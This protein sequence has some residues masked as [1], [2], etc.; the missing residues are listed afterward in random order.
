MLESNKLSNDL[1]VA[2][3]IIILKIDSNAFIEREITKHQLDIINHQRQFQN[4]RKFR[5]NVINDVKQMQI[6]RN[7]AIMYFYDIEKEKYSKFC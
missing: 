7:G 6:S 2:S 5:N 4:S 3:S 1:K